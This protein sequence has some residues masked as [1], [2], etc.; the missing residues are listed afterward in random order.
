M[1]SRRVIG[2][3]ISTSCTGVCC[4]DENEDILLIEPIVLT[5]QKAFIDK[6]ILVEKSLDEISKKYKVDSV[7]I[8][9]KSF[10]V[11]ATS[12]NVTNARNFLHMKINHK[13][14]S[15][16]TKEKV[17]K[18]VDERVEVSWPQKK[19]GEKKEISY[20]MADAYVI[21]LAGLR[22]CKE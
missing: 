22:G 8:S 2:L 13:D 14:K 4:L 16:S 6:C 10:G 19:T 3:D 18:W 1:T 20:D 17:F 12:L 11:T 5:H 21:A 9:Y 15:V 7:F